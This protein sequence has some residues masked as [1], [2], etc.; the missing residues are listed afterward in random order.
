[1]KRITIKDVAKDAGV[2]VTSTSF[3]LNN[4]KG[5]VSEEVRQRVLESVKKLGYIPNATARNLRIQNSD[6]IALIYD[7]AY[8]DDPNAST[9]QFVSNVIKHAGKCGKDILVKL[10]NSE[11]GW[12]KGIQEY[13]N[14]WASQKIEGLIIQTGIININCLEKMKEKGVNFVVIP[15]MEKI[16]G[17]Q[18]IYID[19]YALMKSGIEYLYGKGYKEIY[20]LGMKMDSPYERERGY[21]DTVKKL[22]LKGN[23]LYYT[24]RF[25]DKNELWETIKA[26]VET[27]KE[28]MAIACWNDVDAINVLEILQRSFGASSSSLS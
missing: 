8:L 26:S 21:S 10:I 3:A 4:I 15:P 2:S 19:N 13:I 20:Y 27:K 23:P 25:R 6:T 16:D 22:G 1:M 7:E 5:R 12:E 14:M 11:T 9:L 28:K 17:F 24:N 18:C